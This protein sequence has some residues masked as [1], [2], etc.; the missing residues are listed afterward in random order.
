MADTD[1]PPFRTVGFK[2][3]SFGY[4]VSR[5]FRETLVPLRLEPREFALLRAVA[6]QEG[7][8]QQAIGETLQIPASRMVA[9]VD[10]LEGRQLLERRTNPQDRRARALHL[11]EQGRELL[12]RAMTAALAMERELCTDL[13][14]AEREQLLDLLQ[15]VG[16][17]LGLRSAGHAAHV[18]SGFSD[19]VGA[20]DACEPATGEPA[21]HQG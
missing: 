2:L 21:P 11:T 16:D 15:R 12:G 9:F 1:A 14:A 6:A 18:H 3:S 19:E 10:A 7:R 13:S 5:R 4:A 17:Q 8:S 20:A